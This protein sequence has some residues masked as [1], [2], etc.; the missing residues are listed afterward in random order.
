MAAQ[1]AAWDCR[2]V[3]SWASNAEPVKALSEAHVGHPSLELADYRTEYRLLGP[4]E[5]VHRGEAVPNG[6]RRKRAPLARL[7]L[8]ANRTVSVDALVDALWGEHVPSTAVKMVH[9]YVSQ[10]RIASARTRRDRPR[11]RDLRRPPPARARTAHPSRR[12]ATRSSARSRARR[13]AAP[14]GRRRQRREARV[15]EIGQR[16]GDR[17]RITGSKPAACCPSARASSSADNGLP[18][19]VRWTRCSSGGAS[20]SPSCSRNIRCSAPSL[21]GPSVI[22]S[23]RV[24][25]TA[26]PKLA[27]AALRRAKS[28]RIGSWPR[29]RA[30]YA[31][32][33]AVGGRATSGRRRRRAWAPSARAPAT[34]TET[35]PRS[36]AAPAAE[37]PDPAVKARPRAHAAADPAILRPPRPAPRPG[38]P[39][40]PRTRPASP[41][42]AGVP[43]GRA[44][45]TPT[46]LARPLPRP[47]SCRSPPRPRSSEPA[48]GPP[49]RHERPDRLELAFAPD[50]RRHE[51]TL[52]ANLSPRS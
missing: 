3:P 28:S 48:S 22:T 46:R 42:P 1:P 16:L 24:P 13:S 32:I 2:V 7:L 6:G 43:K 29:R 12:R 37:P 11:R 41:P 36:P 52:R 10:L 39:R 23:I 5:V 25:S 30:A 49:T 45:P 17:Q 8:E 40:R 34:P 47:P 20:P 35:R 21:R 38:D 44:S 50:D 27:A 14:A 51:K 9:I 19:D 31:R 15:D 4:L 26:S 33:A 18:P